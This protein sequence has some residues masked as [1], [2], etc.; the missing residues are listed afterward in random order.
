MDKKE[1]SFVSEKLQNVPCLQRIA[2]VTHLGG[3]ELPVLTCQSEYCR[4]HRAPP[5]WRPEARMQAQK[6]TRA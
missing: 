1:R 2:V 4:H 5:L 3:D 6:G